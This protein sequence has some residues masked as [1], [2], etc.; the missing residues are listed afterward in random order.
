MIL[1]LLAAACGPAEDFSDETLTDSSANISISS[2]TDYTIV[3]VAS[4]KCLQVAGNSTANLARIQLATCNGSSAQNFRVESVSS[5]Y[6]QI[7]NVSSNKCVDVEAKSTADGA[8]VIQYTCS[9]GTNQQFS[10]LDTSDGNVRFVARHSGK[11]LDVSGGS[12]SDGAS[13]IQWPWHGGTNQQFR[14]AAAGSSGGGSN[15][16]TTGGCSSIGNGGVLSSTVVVGS[17]QVWDGGCKRYTAGSSLGDGSQDEGQKPM[18]KLESGATLKNVVLGFPAADGVHTYGTVKLENVVWED[19]GEDALTV[20]SSGTVTIDG[21]SATKGAD[22]V[23]Q[24]NAASTFKVS[25][26]RASDAGKFIRQNGGTTYRVDV[27]IDRCD[28]SDMDEAI[29]RTD[30]STSTVTMTNTRYSNIGDSLFIGVKSSNI[31]TSNN[32]EY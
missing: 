2:S 32:T 24:I 13:L 9:G 8:A 29:F 10:V 5:G 3:G 4:S 25:N 11:V 30:S 19:I 17:G 21:G 7:R 26:F 1:T 12:T 18:F 27:V 15:G 14:L 31:T 6:Y 16:G 20:K 22:K 23:F 28:I